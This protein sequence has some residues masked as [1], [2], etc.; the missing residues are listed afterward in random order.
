MKARESSER[1]EILYESSTM[2]WERMPAGSSRVWI[3]KF[4]FLGRTLFLVT[5]RFGRNYRKC[6]DE[7]DCY[8]LIE[9]MFPWSMLDGNRSDGA[10]EI[11]RVSRVLTAPI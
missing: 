8:R 11:A 9:E 1:K 7:E 10:I 3:H 5:D 2:T 6:A 4:T